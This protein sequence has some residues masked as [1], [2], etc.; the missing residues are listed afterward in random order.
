MWRS[1]C[2]WFL[3]ACLA[4]CDGAPDPGG[5]PD[6]GRLPDAASTP[7]SGAS[8]AG[9]A[10]DAGEP[11]CG[12][13]TCNGAED[14]TRCVVDCG[15]C[16]DPT[17]CETTPLSTA[18]TEYFVSTSGDDANAG[19]SDAPFRSIGK[20]LSVLA[21]GD[22][23]TIRGGL[24]RLMEEPSYDLG[25][26]EGT[27]A[28]YVTIRGY[29]GERVRIY[30]SLSTEGRTWE[31]Y[32]ANV[33]R[34]SAEFLGR[35]P[36]A[37]FH[38]DRR[39]THQS[40]LD[41]GRDHDNVSN[42]VDPDHWT[43]AGADG[44]QCFADN[45]GCY[46]YYYPPAGENPNDEVYELSQRGLGRFWSDHLVVRG[47]EIYYAQP[48]PIFFEGANDIVVEG[49]V[50][51]HTSNGNDNSYG[52]RIWQSGGA[53]VRHNVVFD[54]VYWGGVSNSKGITF[55]VSDPENPHIV[56]YN[57]VYD[58]P[59][60]AAIGVK[61]GVSH[62]IARYNYIHDV[63]TA[64]EP[65]GYRCVW[66]RTN[67]DG[68]QPTDVEYRPGGRWQIYGNVVVEAETGFR[69]AGHVDD[70]GENWVFNNVFYGGGTGIRLGWDGP[71]GHQFFNNVFVHQDAGL[72]LYSGGTTTTVDDYLGQYTA[73][74]NL[75]FGNTADIHLRPNWSG[76][77]TAGVPYTLLEFQ[78]QFDEEMNSISTDPRFV[79]PPSDL[80][81][82]SGSPAAGAGAGD[83]FGAPSV[84]IGAYPLGDWPC[85]RE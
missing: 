75:Y 72:Y 78:S 53:L 63:H 52:M 83:S 36:K 49:N 58:I 54:S 19:T 28:A 17:A 40:D 47:L 57:E 20:G 67:T 12:D 6:A 30:G 22:T 50:F 82:S 51:G 26:D 24:Y 9:P 80:H 79:D 60:Q 2:C 31:A 61:S 13:G 42:L 62:L 15:A 3:I 41:G 68:C 44:S 45:E 56:E 8:D 21:P 38:G 18:G 32:D 34:T 7:D 85:P 73:Y 84:D 10:T 46:I 71:V 48:Q 43:K 69:V 76:G 16:M 4:G 77:P 11:T 64:F 81:L 35:D 23:L 74:N 25:I 14:C 55:M 33:W 66:S 65:G 1:R 27:E 29:P 70:G 39:I 59:G 37:M 5:S